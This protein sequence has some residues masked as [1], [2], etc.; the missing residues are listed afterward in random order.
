MREFGLNLCSLFFFS[1]SL[2]FLLSNNTKFL[3]P[4]PKLDDSLSPETN[5]NGSMLYGPSAKSNCG[6]LQFVFICELV[7][8]SLVCILITNLSHNQKNGNLW[9]RVRLHQYTTTTTTL[10]LAS[11]QR[12]SQRLILGQ[13]LGLSSGT[14]PQSRRRRGTGLRGWRRPLWPAPGG[15]RPKTPFGGR[16]GRQCT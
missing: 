11:L 15:R 3:S 4:F 14:Q 8:R 5:C 16:A 1:Q 2:I 13:L 12:S 7:L 9:K 10:H 6:R